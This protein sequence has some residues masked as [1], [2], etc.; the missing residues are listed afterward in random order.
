MGEFRQNPTD[1]DWEE[2]QGLRRRQEEPTLV[3][4]DRER[5]EGDPMEGYE[6]DLEYRGPGRRLMRLVYAQDGWTVTGREE[7]AVYRLDRTIYGKEEEY[8]E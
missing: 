2:N 4:L 6:W 1:R 7:A 5:G 3:E 8:D